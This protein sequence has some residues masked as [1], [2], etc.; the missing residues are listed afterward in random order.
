M[1]ILFWGIFAAIRDNRN[2]IRPYVRLAAHIRS[3][4]AGARPPKRDR[5]PIIVL[6]GNFLVVVLRASF[7]DPANTHG[8][9]RRADVRIHA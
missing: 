6:A 2:P 8:S 4:P 5:S 3:T 7:Q 1:T 9:T